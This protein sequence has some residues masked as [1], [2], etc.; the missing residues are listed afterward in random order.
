MDDKQGWTK[1]RP[2]SRITGGRARCVTTARG[3][4]QRKGRP[5]T[6]GNSTV[7]Q[8]KP[9]QKSA[10][11]T[12]SRRASKALRRQAGTAAG[13]GVVAVTLTAL[14][15]SHLAH[16]VQIVTGSATWE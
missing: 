9:A 12:K 3:L 14:S 1:F 7:V 16:G 5:F 8:L 11:S 15:L 4:P 13:I 6:M 2:A 10:T